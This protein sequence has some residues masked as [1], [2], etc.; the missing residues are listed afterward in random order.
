MRRLCVKF[1][2]TKKL[3]FLSILCFSSSPILAQPAKT[4]SVTIISEPQAIIWVDD[5]RYGRTGQDGKLTISTVSPGR[6]IIRVR[7][8]GFKEVSKPLLLTQ[9]GDISIPLTKTADEA[10][11]AFQEA[12]R[13]AVTDRESAIE[14]YR[15]AIRLRTRYPEA[16]LALGRV[17]LE[18]DNYEEAGKA[19]R[20]ARILRPGYAEAS[21]VEG[22]ILKESGEEAKAIVA[23]KRAIT[24]GKGFQ[25][26]ANT[27]LGLLYKEK[28][29]GFGG[30]GDFEQEAANYAESVK[31]LKTGLKQLSGAP[32]AIVLYQLL[33][34][35]YERQKAY[36]DA[37]AIY[38]E[39]LHLFPDSNDAPAV[40][41]FIV[42]IKKQMAAQQ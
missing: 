21:A 14:I 36:K 24:E 41:S 10:E 42:Q 5:V 40:R 17:L 27:G 19:I 16:Y 18:I 29:E 7:A 20:A 8:D 13:L 31:Y 28:A 39:F 12:E 30:S 22:R 35:V 3:I 23:F 26:E 37:I 1:K 38:E 6:H 4:R 32:D 15:K 11:L 2:L 25:P 9:K 33:G 34:L